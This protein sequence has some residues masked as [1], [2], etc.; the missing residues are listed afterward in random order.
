VLKIPLDDISERLNLG[1]ILEFV[2]KAL[3]LAWELV[4]SMA[5]VNGCSQGYKVF[6]HATVVRV[7]PLCFKTS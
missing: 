6:L 3:N 4:I 2:D 1:V 5:L 7:S